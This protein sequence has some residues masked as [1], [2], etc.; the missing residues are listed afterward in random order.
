MDIVGVTRYLTLEIT[1]QA[2]RQAAFPMASPDHG[3]I[4]WHRP[5]PRAIIPLDS[6]HI[7]RRLLRSL[8]H[9][10]FDVTYDHDFA[11]V[12]LGCAENR[13]VWISREFHETYGALYREGKAHSV[14]VLRRRR[15]VGGLYG[16]HLG[17][18]FF[19]ESM[20]HR[21]TNASKIALIRLVQRLRERDFALLDVQYLTPH[22]A[23]FGAVEI[24]HRE[25]I[26]RLRHALS[27]SCSFP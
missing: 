20:F 1:E 5:D 11:A 19:A 8:K 10:P 21:V 17:G 23:R 13:P 14:E 9:E 27:R 3:L 25:Y 6:L 15:L 26:R 2:Y 4:T 18:A 7:P 22:L 24:P 12:M 16:V